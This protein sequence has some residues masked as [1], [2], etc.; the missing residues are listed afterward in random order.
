MKYL[1]SFKWSNLR[2]T[3]VPHAAWEMVLMR[4]FLLWPFWIVVQR[5][6]QGTQPRPNGIAHFVDLTWLANPSAQMVL[7]GA[8]WIAGVLFVSGRAMIPALAAISAILVAKGTL[9]NSQGATNHALQLITLVSL[10]ML[11]AYCFRWKCG[12]T[13]HESHVRAVHWA[14]V[15]IA[16]SYVSA[17]VCKLF[18]SSEFWIARVPYMALQILKSNLQTYYTN[19]ENQS[20]VAQNF[21]YWIVEHPHLARMLFG[22]GLL[23]E[24]FC[25]LALINR[26]WALFIGLGMVGMHWMIHVVMSLEFKHH[27]YLLLIFYVNAPWLLYAGLK[28]L[29]GGREKKSHAV[30]SA[31]VS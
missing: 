26:W 21:A 1:K 4:A 17:A 12:W 11:V 15:M 5:T 14:K 22:A 29:R 25:F 30:V 2:E 13:R 10:T 23:L 31:G 3:I 9:I 24:L 27:V 28:W 8:Y 16:A 19:L 7:N 20:P 6:V 18:A